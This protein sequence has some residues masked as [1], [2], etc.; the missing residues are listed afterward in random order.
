MSSW[1]DSS[2]S[3]MYVDGMEFVFKLTILE[4]TRLGLVKKS[5]QC[6][7]GFDC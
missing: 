7:K 3:T 1:D 4:K 6:K 5:R 2:R